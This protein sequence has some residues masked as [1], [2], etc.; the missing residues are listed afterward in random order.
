MAAASAHADR[1]RMTLE[2][3]GQSGDPVL[4]ESFLSAG[5]SAGLPT[6]SAEVS[7]VAHALAH[8]HA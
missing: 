2:S 4:L 3:G 6:A 7:V 8:Q 1:L 5:L